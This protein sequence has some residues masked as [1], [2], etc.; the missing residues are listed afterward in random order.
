MNGEKINSCSRMR[1]IVIFRIHSEESSAVFV[2]FEIINDFLPRRTAH[3]FEDNERGPMSVYPR[4][5][6]AE[7]TP[8]FSVRINVLL[9]I[10]EGGI[11]DAGGTRNEKINIAR[12]G[13]L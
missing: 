5:H 11:V 8:G 12:H 10:I 3:I 1:N 2:L 9:L 4:H 6:S 7:R 13:N